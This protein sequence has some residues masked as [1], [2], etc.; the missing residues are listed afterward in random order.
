MLWCLLA[1]FVLVDVVA[2]AVAAVAAAV[3]A[4]AAAVAAIAVG[5]IDATATPSSAAVQLRVWRGGALILSLWQLSASCRVA[6]E[7][8]PEPEEEP[9]HGCGKQPMPETKPAAWCAFCGRAPIKRRKCM[10]C[11]LFLGVDVYY[12]DEDCQRAD[13]KLPPR[14]KWVCCA[15]PGPEGH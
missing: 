6:M 11:Y 10:N 12:C 8:A 1:Y 3:V 15:E 13:W 9:R 14:H 7:A 2:A 4:V 5:N